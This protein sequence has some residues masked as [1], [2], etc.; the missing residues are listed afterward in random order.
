MAVLEKPV[1]LLPSAAIRLTALCGFNPVR[2]GEL[3][4]A[5]FQNEKKSQATAQR[6][7]WLTLT[8]AIPMGIGCL[9]ECLQVILRFFRH[10]VAM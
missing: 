1:V 3:N 4:A 2:V 8:K 7:T 9:G 5:D 6:V 10:Q